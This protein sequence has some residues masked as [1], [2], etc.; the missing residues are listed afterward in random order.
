VPSL[1]GLGIILQPTR[2][3]RAG[4]SH[5]VPSALGSIHLWARQSRFEPAATQYID[6]HQNASIPVTFCPMISV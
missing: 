1:R 6:C 5:I 4:L 3:C 2:H